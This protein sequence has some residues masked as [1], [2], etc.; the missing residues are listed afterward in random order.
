MGYNQQQMICEG[1]KIKTVV[2][3]RAPPVVSE[4]S[5]VS[6]SWARVWVAGGDVRRGKVQF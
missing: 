3:S 6:V 1:Q 2:S 4:L 5:V